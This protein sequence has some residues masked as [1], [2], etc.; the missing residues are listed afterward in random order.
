MYSGSP[1]HRGREMHRAT[2]GGYGNRYRRLELCIGRDT[3][4]R[5]LAMFQV[6]VAKRGSQGFAFSSIATE[7]VGGEDILRPERDRIK[8]LP[9]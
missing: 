4:T 3:F 1:A 7:Y 9:D 5:K 8:E 6:T 2:G